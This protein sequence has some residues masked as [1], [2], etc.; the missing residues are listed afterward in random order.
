MRWVIL[1]GCNRVCLVAA[2]AIMAF[3]TLLS[4]AVKGDQAPSLVPD[5]DG[6][7]FAIGAL[8]GSGW[9]SFPKRLHVDSAIYETNSGSTVLSIEINF[10]LAEDLAAAR[11][12]LARAGDETSVVALDGQDIGMVTNK[13]LGSSEGIRFGEIE[14]NLG[15]I[16][17]GHHVLAFSIADDG[18]GNGRHYLDAI[19]LRGELSLV[20]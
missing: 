4:S 11:L 2:A 9:D 13:M 5:E 1:S 15:A 16:S 3:S 7:V 18:R 8:D 20:D 14:L 19:V 12:T 10:T 6:V 17:A